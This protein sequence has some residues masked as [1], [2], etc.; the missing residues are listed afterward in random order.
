MQRIGSIRIL[1]LL[2][3]TIEHHERL[4]DAM[5]LDQRLAELMSDLQAR[6][7]AIGLLPERDGVFEAREVVEGL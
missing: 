3:V 6:R 2:N 4:G 7:D 5:L 1:R